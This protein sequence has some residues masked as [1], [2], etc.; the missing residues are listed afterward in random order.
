V[1]GVPPGTEPEP[2]V[3]RPEPLGA[4]VV[5]V[6]DGS[7]VDEVAVVLD[8]DSSTDD[9]VDESATEEEDDDEDE[10]VVVPAAVSSSPRFPG[11]ASARAMP[12]TKGSPPQRRGARTVGS[13]GTHLDSSGAGDGSRTRVTS[14]EGWSSSH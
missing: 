10:D 3:P 8:E 7:S 9:D 13:G 2:P 4:A 11:L 1:S 6:V 14:L 5:V 12:T